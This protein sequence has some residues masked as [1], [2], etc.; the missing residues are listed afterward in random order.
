MDNIVDAVVKVKKKGTLQIAARHRLD[1]C[2]MKPEEK[3]EDF[4]KALKSLANL[5]GYG[6]RK[7]SIL[8]HP[9]L[10]GHTSTRLMINILYMG[11]AIT[12]DKVFNMCKK[13]KDS[14]EAT[15]LPMQT[16]RRIRFV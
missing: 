7:D 12:L 15:E 9:I 6:T 14:M 8:C 11:D 16:T 13:D 5:C 1:N 2:S 3:F 4:L 10:Q